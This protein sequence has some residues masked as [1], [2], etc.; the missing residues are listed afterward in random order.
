MTHVTFRGLS[1]AHTEWWPQR[2]DPVDGQAAISVPAVLQG[3]GMEHCLLENCRV[4]HAGNYAIQLGRGCRHNRVNGCEL[5]DLGGGGIKVGEGVQRDDVSQQ[6]HAN[7]ITNNHIHDGG[8]V[9]HQAVG[10]WIGQ[11]YGNRITHNHIHD[12]YYTGISCGWTWGYGKSLARDNLIERNDVHDL[13]KGWLSDMG[14]IYTLGVQPGTVIRGNI[15]HTIAGH[16]YGGWG[17]YFDE[18]STNIVAENNLVHDTT[19]GGFHQH[20]GKENIV[21]NNIFAFGRDAQIQ[22]TRPE[23]HKSFTFER[24]IVYWKEG[25]LLAGNWKTHNVAFDHNIYWREGKEGVRF[26]NESWEQ[27]RSQGL[28]THSLL[29]DPRFVNSAKRNFRLAND[30]PALK[31]GFVPLELSTVGVQREADKS[32][33]P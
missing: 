31:L 13:G 32:P 10:V 12:L 18:G 14:G 3:E 1:F 27:W 24:N 16:R 2:S 15:F 28:D 17:I 8:R 30:S 19:H 7:V 29:A 5:F 11:S 9:F 23:D 6:T 20:Y 26:G 22:R 4:A 33:S 25:K 21:R